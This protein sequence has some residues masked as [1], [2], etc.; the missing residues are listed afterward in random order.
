M[1]RQIASCLLS[2]FFCLPAVH[3][4]KVGL[5][6]SGGGAKGAA[7]IGVIKALEENNVPVDYVAGTSIGAIVG[8]LYAMGYS[9]DEML[10]LMLSDEFGYWQSGTVEDSY[11]YYFK[12]PDD[13]P[14]FMRFSIDLSDSLRAKTHILPNSLVNP[15]QMNQAFMGL[16]AQATA[17]SGWNF[18]GLFVPFRCVSSDVYNKKS[19]VWR[20]GDLGE[21]V[22]SSMTFPFFFKP[23][24]KDGVPLFDGGIYNNFP[25]DIVKE[26]FQPD[27]IFGSAVAGHENTPSENPMN[28]IEKMIMQHTDY[29]VDE[30]D[31]MMVWFNFPD[32][33]LLDFQRAQELMTIGYEQTLT[34]IDSIRKRVPRSVTPDELAQ[35]RKA[36]KE[37]LPPLK[38]KNIYI[39][40]VSDAQRK[41]IDV[42]LRRDINGEFSMEEFKQAY[43]K[44]LS[45]SKIREIIPQAVYN[46]KNKNFDLY[47][48]VKINQEIKVSIGGNISS[49][50]ANQ[51]YLGIRYQELGEYAT[52]LHSDF[53]MGNSYS[54]ASLDGRMY[55]PT[56]IPMYLDLQGVYGYRKY[57]QNQSLFYEDML[58]AFIKQREKFIKMKL[59]FPFLKKSKVEIGAAYGRLN[60]NYYQTSSVVFANPEFD[61]SWYDLFH[62]F[63]RVGRNTLNDKQYP[64]GGRQQFFMAQYVSGTETYRPM[65]RSYGEN[66][67]HSW[68]QLKG[69]WMNYPALGNSFRLGLMAEA[70]LSSKKLM[71]NYSASILQAPAFTP[72]PHSK[73]V[74]NEAFRSNQYAAAGVMPVFMLNKMFHLRVEAYGFLPVRPI[75]K[76]A[77]SGEGGNLQYYGETFDLFKY[78]AET[79]LVF[80]L[81]FVSVSLFANGYSYPEKNFNFGLNIGFLIFTP[82][83]LD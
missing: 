48:D 53:Q 42:Q 30:E 59:G 80:Q 81:P 63:V 46:R 3:A 83:F 8:S 66:H 10:A 52:E 64:T 21:A 34:M 29:H 27:F 9:P 20:N 22:R 70:V 58:P 74:F 49:H 71:S 69:R 67:N 24:W 65:V 39:T 26:D 16:Y 75:M 32:V 2:A 1:K 79:S 33:S 73:I 47:L 76:G 40:G 41:Y 54:G 6:L 36:Y 18:D 61:R 68:I 4:Q 45:D 15:I 72:T 51:L 13:T 62:A 17:K 25:V 12:K 50:Q 7:H 5:V 55:M 57:S 35:R 38:F 82:G 37:S 14:D 77:V 23:I 43:F 60:D 44:M 78:M 19:I 31:G 56:R 11:I 28:Q